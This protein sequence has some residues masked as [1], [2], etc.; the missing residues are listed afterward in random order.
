MNTAADLH[1]FAVRTAV[2]DDVPALAGIYRRASLS[3]DGDRPFLLAHPEA[4]VFDDALVHDGRTRL[5]TE[6]GTVVGFATTRLVDGAVELDDL[7]VDPDHMRR[8]IA[9]RLVADAVDLGRGRA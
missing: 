5:A 1:R 3:N 2:A 6:D 4:L 9:R 7:F 8:G